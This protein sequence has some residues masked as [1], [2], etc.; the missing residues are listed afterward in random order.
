LWA[1]FGNASLQH[2]RNL[3]GGAL[4]PYHYLLTELPIHLRYFWLLFFPL[5]Q[6][7]DHD[8]P[9]FR[10]PWN[11][12]VLGSALAIAALVGAAWKFRKREPLIWLATLFYFFAMS[13]E[14]SFVPMTDTAFE[15]RLY[16]PSIGFFLALTCL[17]SRWVEA[18][19]RP[20]RRSTVA[21]VAL[22][23]L[24]LLFAAR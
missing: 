16:F 20:A 19:P 12:Q 10:S 18:W 9:V 2:V 24:G 5:G 7:I 23:A 11:W 1:L 14:S 21:V 8:F 4:S 17:M 22:L 3:R 13:L 6:S 15:H